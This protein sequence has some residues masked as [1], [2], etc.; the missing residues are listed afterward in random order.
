M[1]WTTI[2]RFRLK[3]A[4]QYIFGNHIQFFL[5]MLRIKTFARLLSGFIWR[6]ASIASEAEV[7]GEA[8]KALDSSLKNTINIEDEFCDKVEEGI[9][10]PFA[11]E[12][13]RDREDERS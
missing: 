7:V 13:R 5:L 6:Y 8:A 4:L 10:R 1:S 12:M 11:R 3:V 2:V 9:C